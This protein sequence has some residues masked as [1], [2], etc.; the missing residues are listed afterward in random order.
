[1]ADE[2]TR[3]ADHRP[4][5]TTSGMSLVVTLPREFRAGRAVS[6]AVADI[7][8]AFEG[9]EADLAVRRAFERQMRLFD[10]IEEIVVPNIHF[11]DMPATGKGHGDGENLG[12]VSWSPAMSFGSRT[13]L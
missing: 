7:K 9:A 10:E 2:A 8:E 4:S 12:H 13:R 1:M 3:G 11:D 6:R 5:A